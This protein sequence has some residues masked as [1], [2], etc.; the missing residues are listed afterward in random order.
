[1]RYFKLVRVYLIHFLMIVISTTLLS[2]SLQRESLTPPPTL[3]PTVSPRSIGN[4][5]NFD[6]EECWRSTEY[7]YQSYQNTRNLIAL[8][9]GI[10]LPGIEARQLRYIEHTGDLRWSVELDRRITSIAADEELVYTLTGFWVSAY[11]VQTGELVWV[12]DFRLPY[13]KGYYSRLQN[14]RLYIYE[15][16]NPVYVFDKSTGQLVNTLQVP[17]I[18]QES[19]LLLILDQDEWLLRDKSNKIKLIE[20]QTIR[21]ETNLSGLAH[22]FPEIYEEILIVSVD[23]YR[24]VFDRLAAI[25]LRTGELIW[26]RNNDEFYSNFIVENGLIYV[27]SKEARILVLDP[28]TGQTVGYAELMPPRVDANQGTSAVAAY[29]NKLYVYFLDSRELIAFGKNGCVNPE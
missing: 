22:Q 12:S 7:I 14:N 3:T 15:Y 21:W 1:M 24:S 29:N 17:R 5:H 27:I 13:H 20:N 25:N 4:T 19:F 10:V 6:W 8:E 9:E 23:D 28:M 11:D 2:C 26:Q 18:S 16:A